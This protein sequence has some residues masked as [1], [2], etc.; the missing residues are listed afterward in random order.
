MG[1]QVAMGLALLTYVLLSAITPPYDEMSPFHALAADQHRRWPGGRS[2]RHRLDSYDGP[3]GL[4]TTRCRC[5]DSWSRSEGLV[6][7][8]LYIT[9]VA[10][11]QPRALSLT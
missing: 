8:Y 4:W 7:D 2:Y 6:L 9:E 10:T 11:T 3:Q 1:A 5:L